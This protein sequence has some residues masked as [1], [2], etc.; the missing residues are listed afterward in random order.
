MTRRG[1][2]FLAALGVAAV[3]GTAWA[4]TAEKGQAAYDVVILNGRVMDPETGFDAV[5]N[6]G[7]RN[8][9]IATITEDAIAGSEEI[10]A[11]GL[12]V[13]PGFIDTQTHGQTEFGNKLYL[14][15]G[16]TTPMDLE[17][18]SINVEKFYSQREGKWQTNFGTPVSQELARM[19]VLDGMALEEPYT[20]QHL[21]ALRAQSSKDDGVPGWAVTP[22]NLEQM[23]AVTA[24]LDEE[25]RKGALGVGSTAGYMAKGLTTY[26]MFEAQKAAARYGRVTA[27][28]VR[29]LGNNRPPTEGVLG[30]DELFANAVALS[31]PLLASHNN[32]F[33]WWEVQEKL[34]LAR[35]QGYNMW[36]EHY[37]YTAGSTTIG[38]EFLKPEGLELLG[39]GYENMID[40]ATGEAFTQET[41]EKRA[42][43]D[44][45][46]GIVLFIPAR[47]EWLPEWLK[48]PHVT[49]AGDGL[50]TTDI[51]GNDLPWEAPPE[52]F[53]GHPRTAGAH[54][55]TLRLGREHKVPLMQTLRQLS[56][57]SALHLGEA[58]LE[59]M[60]VRGRMQ[61]GMVADVTV[62]DPA[63]VRDNADYVI[64]KH[65]LPSTG[66]P[67][68][69]VNGTI[70]V[71]DSEVVDGVYPGQA[72]R[73]PV[74]DKG[75]FV[76]ASREGWLKSHTVELD[77]EFGA[78]AT[79]GH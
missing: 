43:E 67:Y 18:G 46:Y 52:A 15:D 30:F 17:I 28:H 34:E 44:P 36:G 71:R 41:F 58:G 45:G 62:F 23:N 29:L 61:E 37:P 76:P 66:I 54:A 40:P 77:D 8:G 6:V 60:K 33:G 20:A 75:R 2:Y 59:S 65:G 7:I 72:I 42:A 16:V 12:V 24:I 38:A 21:G 57:W 9:R 11:K 10:E 32:N 48:L 3:L 49:V 50:W 63:T 39:L 73:Y 47:E 68:V 26:E 19:V 70:I 79:E 1:R 31:A 22:S 51:D 78:S 25:L 56:Y 64:G 53:N 4:E 55:K 74:E 27:S 35:K 14:R 69:L 13:A 5:R